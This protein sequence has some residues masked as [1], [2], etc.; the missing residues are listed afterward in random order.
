MVQIKDIGHVE[1][2]AGNQD[3]TLQAPIGKEDYPM[4]PWPSSSCRTTNALDAAGRRQWRKMSE[5][6]QTVSARGS[7]YAIVYD[8]TPFIQRVD[9]RGRPT[10]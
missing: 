9:Q 5:L 8:M 10:P 2:A 4:Q 1:L 6:K 7:D 3:I